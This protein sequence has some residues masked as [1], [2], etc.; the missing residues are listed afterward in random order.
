[1][2]KSQ[3]IHFWILEGSILSRLLFLL[4]FNEVLSLLKQLK[5]LIYADDTLL[6]YY[7]LHLPKIEKTLSENLTKMLA[8]KRASPQP[9]ER[10]N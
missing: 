7:H 6:Y 8:G 9:Q 3:R 2:S 4:H 5:G 1:M 10:K